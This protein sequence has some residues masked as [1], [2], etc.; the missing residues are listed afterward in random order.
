[1]MIHNDLALLNYRHLMYSYYSQRE[2]F[3]NA[4]GK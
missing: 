2:L 1:M 3:R 4:A